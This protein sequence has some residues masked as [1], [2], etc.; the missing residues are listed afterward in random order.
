VTIDDIPLS[1]LLEPGLTTIS[2]PG[3]QTG[4]A[5]GELL[6]RLLHGEETGEHRRFEGKLVERGS[7]ASLES[8]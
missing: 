3:F 7:V 5:A 6:F 8:G 4:A 1:R 2:Q